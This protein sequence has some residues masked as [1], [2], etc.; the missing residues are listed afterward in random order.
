VLDKLNEL[1]E[2]VSEVEEYL[3][4]FY[5][6]FSGL[7]VLSKDEIS[8]VNNLPPAL[9]MVF[10]KFYNFNNSAKEGS[11]SILIDE[12][13]DD[14]KPKQSGLIHPKYVKIVFNL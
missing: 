12:Y 6:K 2:Y 8:H 11:I 7:K 10:N 14:Y 13:D 3:R 5:E 4:K 9:T 1:P